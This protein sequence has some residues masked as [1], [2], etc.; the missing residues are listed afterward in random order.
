M[1]HFETTWPSR[2]EV[3]GRGD[4]P[5]SDG[6]QVAGATGTQGEV[7]RNDYW[8]I[9]DPDILTNEDFD[10]CISDYLDEI[11]VSEWPETVE[12]EGWISRTVGDGVFLTGSLLERVLE[13]LDE[14]YCGEDGEYTEASDTMKEAESVFIAAILAEYVLEWAKKNRP[15]LLGAP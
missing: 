14:E 15:E 8:A 13:S 10:Q 11:V 4:H 5:D 1:N 6:R 2:W 9:G 12:V 7:M 3:D